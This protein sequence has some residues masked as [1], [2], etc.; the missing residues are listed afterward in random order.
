ML[1]ITVLSR[2][3]GQ[4]RLRGFTSPQNPP[5]LFERELP[6][7]RPIAISTLTGAQQGQPSLD[8]FLEVHWGPK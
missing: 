8:H 7:T 4:P 3:S 5:H 2:I 6:A 1:L